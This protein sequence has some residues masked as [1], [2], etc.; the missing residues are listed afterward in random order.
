MTNILFGVTG[1]SGLESHRLRALPTGGFM[2]T[3]R[4]KQLTFFANPLQEIAPDAFTGLQSL[5]KLILFDNRADLKLSP[6]ALANLPALVSVRLTKCRIYQLSPD[7]FHNSSS[8]TS[9]QLGGNS[10]SDL[11]AGLFRDQSKLESLLLNDNKI[12][13]LRSDVFWPLKQLKELSLDKNLIEVLPGQLFS[14]LTRLKS[15]RM[16][17]N[18]LTQIAPDAFIDAV[19]L[20]V[21]HLANN[22]LTMRPPG[23]EP[24]HNVSTYEEFE[25]QSPFSSLLQLKELDL[26]RNAISIIFSDWRFVLLNLKKLNLAW[27]RIRELTEKFNKP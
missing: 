15:I 27:N 24:G 20:E 13:S 17:S 1:T 6:R 23:L 4:L 7:T 3:P 10:I 16:T 8:I 14:G 21:V 18:R 19:A 22:S 2:H 26:S 25:Q 5:E 9:L 11:P 12:K